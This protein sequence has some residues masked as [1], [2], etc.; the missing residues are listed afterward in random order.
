M[1]YFD[2]RWED[3]D[4]ITGETP[5]EELQDYYPHVHVIDIYEDVM[6]DWEA[7]EEEAINDSQVFN[8]VKKEKRARRNSD[9]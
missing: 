2:T 9:L 6:D 4:D 7:I 1:N 3:D 8:Q 5:L